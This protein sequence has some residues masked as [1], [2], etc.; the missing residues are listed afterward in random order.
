[1]TE[2]KKQR[3][4]LSTKKIDE[5]NHIFT[6]EELRNLVA[7]GEELTLSSRTRFH[8]SP[9]DTEEELPVRIW[10]EIPPKAPKVVL[11]KVVKIKRKTNLQLKV[12]EQLENRKKEVKEGTAKGYVPP[13]TGPRRRKRKRR[14]AGQ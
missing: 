12:Q 9:L 10:A 7:R 13:V 6:F 3:L 14:I 11:G 8:V 1:M 2:N 4:V 5:T